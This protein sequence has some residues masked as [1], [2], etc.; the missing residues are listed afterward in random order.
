MLINKEMKQIMLL[1]MVAVLGLTA[2]SDNNKKVSIKKAGDTLAPHTSDHVYRCSMHPEVTGKA[3]DKC[4]KC[5]MEL[6]HMDQPVTNGNTYH[7][8]FSVQPKQIEPQKEVTLSLTP[9]INGK[10]GQ[11][12]PLD[13]E[14]TKKIHLIVVNNDL[15]YFHH[16]HPEINKDGS[17]SVKEAFPAPGNY[18]LFADY[19]PSSGNHT[20]DK[21]AVS[22][23]GVAPANK[24][25]GVDQLTGDAGDG[26]T[27]SLIPD[28][29][30][31]QSNRAMHIAGVLKQDG[32]D[33]D[34]AMLDNYLGAKAHVVVVSLKDKD[35]LHVHPEVENGKFDLHT[36]FTKA[37]LYRGW[38]QFQSKGKLHVADFVINVAQ[39]KQGAPVDAMS[40]MKM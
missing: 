12:V 30:K 36:V 26:L 7:M 19:K 34:P 23:N 5:G 10:E 13:I 40:G 38:I 16:I 39:G 24:K 1:L 20:I 25:F 21:I 29:G 28:G 3:G 4:Y 27:V 6:V 15:S 37:G 31:F 22:V 33:I 8:A 2:C 32:K 18:I 17:Y 11:Q 35:Y 14:H 9:Q